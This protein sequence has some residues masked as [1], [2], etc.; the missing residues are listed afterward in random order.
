MSYSI[1]IK[2][3]KLEQSNSPTIDLRPVSRILEGTEARAKVYEDDIQDLETT[4]DQVKAKRVHKL[5][6]AKGQ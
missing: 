6:R 5:A 3:E 1:Q 4:I 2:A